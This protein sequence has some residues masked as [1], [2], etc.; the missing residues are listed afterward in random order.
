MKATKKKLLG[1][2]ACMLLLCAVGQMCM[3]KEIFDISDD[4]PFDISIG[5]VLMYEPHSY[6]FGYKQN[7]ETDTTVFEIWRGGGCCALTYTIHESCKW[8]EVFPTSGTSHGERDPITVT[9]NTTGISI[10]THTYGVTIISNGGSGIFTVK[11]MVIDKTHPYL[12]YA[13]ESYD[14]GDMAEGET[15]ST[16]FEI[17]NKGG[18][19]LTYTLTEECTWIKVFPT[20]GGSQG[21]HD[22]ITVSINTTGLERG[23]H[24]CDVAIESNGGNKTFTVVVNIVVSPSLSYAPESYDFG[25]MAEGE[26]DSTV[27][28]IW[29]GGAG[30]LTYTLTE[31][32]EWVNVSPTS[33]E[34][35]GEHDP[36]I[37]SV[38]TT[39]LNIGS[40]TFGI[41]I[42]S[43]GGNGT[44][45][46]AVT[47]VGGAA[48]IEIEISGG[49]G[50]TATIKNVGNVD[51]VG[52]EWSI[53]FDG[54]FILCPSGGT[55]NGTIDIPAG[56]EFSVKVFV[57]GFGNTVITVT[58]NDVEKTAD[59]FV[60]LFFVLGV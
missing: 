10:G 55:S 38:D 60:L 32:C 43:N 4:E 17:W 21:E 53:T 35:K 1:I 36:I 54:G 41:Y 26:T 57:L 20:S 9:I 19:L 6:D 40:Y 33:G 29:N 12:G 23:P 58:V 15:D 28:E 44:F 39:G 30:T 7:N 50:V 22:P 27:F 5:R 2:F 18:D 34:S 56:E 3:G 48:E 52:V 46:V 16:V 14:F 8:I 13:P 49:F 47:V 51:A 59:G 11:V 37:V 45:T 42:E 31:D 25:D 24:T